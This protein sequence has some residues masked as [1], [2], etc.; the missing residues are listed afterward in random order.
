M[1]RTMSVD[2]SMTIT[3]AVPRPE[4][5]FQPVEIHRRV[6]DLRG[7]DQRHRRAA[8]DDRQQIVPA[9]ATPPHAFRSARLKGMLIAFFDVARRVHV[10]GDLEQ[11]GA[12]V[13]GHAEA[14]N[15]AAPRR[16]MVGATAMI[17]R[18]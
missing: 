7:R 3:A 18:C 4:P 10:A 17:R 2:L 8:G 13:V 1:A 9:A 16:R 15:Q 14:L 11:L 5:S 6:H 12:G